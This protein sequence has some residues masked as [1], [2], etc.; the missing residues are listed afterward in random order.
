MPADR[1][2][3]FACPASPNGEYLGH[4]EPLYLVSALRYMIGFL[5]GGIVGLF[6]A[7]VVTTAIGILAT[8]EHALRGSSGVIVSFIAIPACGILGFLKFGRAFRY[9]SPGHRDS[10]A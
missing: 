4:W 3:P 9:L 7:F 2:K 5:I 1:H 6:L 8:D 10:D